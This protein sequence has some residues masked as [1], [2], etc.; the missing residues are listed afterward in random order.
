LRCVKV[1]LAFKTFTIKTPPRTAEGGERGH[2]FA[3]G[4]ENRHVTP[5]AA[6][7]QLH[8]KTDF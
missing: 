6:M 3:K 2:T 8:N 4:C 7:N 5:N 1:L